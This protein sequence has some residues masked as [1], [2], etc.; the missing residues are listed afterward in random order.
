[1]FGWSTSA[2]LGIILAVAL[3]NWL[4]VF[5]HF[6]FD[7]VKPIHMLECNIWHCQIAN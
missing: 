3:R 6:Q 4:K 1:M 2:S 5:E 7:D